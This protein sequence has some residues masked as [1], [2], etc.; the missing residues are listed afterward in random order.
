MTLG[1]EG[2]GT[3]PH[4][5]DLHSEP[6]PHAFPNEFRLRLP[7]T[8]AIRCREEGRAPKRKKLFLDIVSVSCGHSSEITVIGLPP[9]HAFL[10]LPPP[11]AITDNG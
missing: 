4:E 11:F 3:S 10:R 8:L 9:P 2:V 1:H 5:P 6:K 7:V